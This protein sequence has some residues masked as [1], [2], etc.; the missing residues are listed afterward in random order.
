[1]QAGR[2]SIDCNIESKSQ[3]EKQHEKSVVDGLHN[4]QWSLILLWATMPLWQCQLARM[5][6][7]MH[8]Y[9]QLARKQESL[10]ILFACRKEVMLDV[11]VI[12]S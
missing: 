10:S 5:W 1:M 6:L 8:A 12:H 4:L 7:G 2:K 3:W 11:I 9:D